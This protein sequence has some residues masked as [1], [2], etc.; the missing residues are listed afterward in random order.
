VLVRMDVQMRVMD[1][2]ETTR[3]FREQEQTTR[4]H[5]PIVAMTAHAMKGDRE[6]C[7][8]AGMDDYLAKPVRANLLYET[9]DRIV[10][11]PPENGTATELER[12]SERETEG[13]AGH[14]EFNEH[15]D[16]G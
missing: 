6:R 7:L 16:R 15:S 8:E 5:V 2:C 1:G 10:E 3:R 9:L 14:G 13:L 4:A 11:T 12:K